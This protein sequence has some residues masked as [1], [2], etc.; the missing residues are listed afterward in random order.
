MKKSLFIPLFIILLSA[1]CFSQENKK[2]TLDI[3]VFLQGPY[4]NYSMTDELDKENLIP[5]SQPYNEKPWDYNGEEHVSKIPKDIVDWILVELTNDT[6][7]SKVISQ[8]AAFLR[9]DGKITSLDGENPLT[10]KNINEKSCYIVIKH[11]NH[12]PV[13]SSR[14]ISLN[15]NVHYDFTLSSQNAFGNSLIDL[16]NSEFGMISGDSD[17]NGE[18]NKYDFKEVASNLL[19]VGYEN[20][21]LDMNGVVNILDYKI[22]NS[23]LSKRTAVR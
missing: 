20:A 7:R 10:F 19:K 13:M 8:K 18:I 16:G 14:S 2:V 4:S 15:D 1:L 9:I 3:R 12:L 23:N 5:L 17:S 21:D 6:N 22:I 11:R